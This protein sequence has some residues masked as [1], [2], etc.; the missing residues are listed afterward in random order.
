MFYMRE[1]LRAGAGIGVLPTF[2]AAADVA[3]GSLVC[4]LPRWSL[5][6]GQLWMVSP[7]GNHPARKVVAFRDFV[8]ESLR[9]RAL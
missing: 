7:G 9:S 6:A 3:A 8:V 2:V 4:A 5:L 1:S